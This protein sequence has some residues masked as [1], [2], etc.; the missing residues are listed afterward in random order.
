MEGGCYL[1]YR[2]KNLRESDTWVRACVICSL[3]KRVILSDLCCGV[4]H[5][6]LISSLTLPEILCDL[7]Q[8]TECLHS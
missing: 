2:Q 7:Q 3:H 6:D 5:G 1:S 4:K 8:N